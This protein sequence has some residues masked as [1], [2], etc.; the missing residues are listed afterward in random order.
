MAC[1]YSMAYVVDMVYMAVMV[2][3]ASMVSI[4][5]KQYNVAKTMVQLMF[6]GRLYK[7][8]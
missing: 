2:I 8:R 4:I 3:M 6:E 7:F 1:M 5:I